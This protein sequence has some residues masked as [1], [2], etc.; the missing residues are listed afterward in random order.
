MKKLLLSTLLLTATLGAAA[1]NTPTSQMEK[2][3]RGLVVIPSGSQRFLSWR[4][5][6]TDDEDRTRF[7]I[8]RNGKTVAARNLYQTSYTDKTAG[9]SYQIITLVDGVPV[10]TSK[11]VKPWSS[12]S[13]TISMQRPAAG[14]TKPYT[15][16]NT[17]NKEK[18]TETYTNGQDYTYSPNDCSVGDVDGDGEYEIFVKWDPSNARDNSHGGVTGIVLIDCYKLDGTF[19][20]RIDLG[21]NIRAGAHYTQYQVYDY[22]G[23]GRAELMCKTAPGSKDGEGNYVNQAATDERIKAASNTKDWVSEGVGRVNGGQE[24]LTVFD[25]LTGRA[26]HTIAYNPNRNAKS[27]L[28]EAA[29]TFNWD[30]RSGKSDLGSYGNRGERYLAATAY[31]DGTDKPASAIFC[32]GYYSFA[33]VWAVSFDGTKLIPRWLHRSDN[34]NGSTYSVVTY[35]AN[36]NASTKTYTGN[37]PTSGSG[38]G[39]MFGNGNHN[40]SVA[41]VDGDGYDEVVWGSSACDHDGR[42]LY[43]TG[44]G[45]GDAIHIG[46]HCPDRPGLEVFQIHEAGSYGWDLHDA[47]TG[48]I[49]YSATGSEDNGRGIAGAFDTKVRGSLFWSANDRQ[50]RSAVTGQTVSSSSGSM[51]FRIYWD[52]DLYEELLDGNKI[53]KWNGNG[54]IRLTTLSGNTCNGTKNT[55]NLQAD[56]LGDWREEVILWNGTTNN[57]VLYTPTTKTNYRVPTLMH[58][59]TYRMAICWQNSAYNQ[60]PHLGYY[61][62]DTMLPTIIGDKELTVEAGENINWVLRGRYATYLTIDYK[63]VPS[64]MDYEEDYIDPVLT[65]TGCLT[66]AG[67]YVL[68]ITVTGLDGKDVALSVTI[69]VTNTTGITTAESHDGGNEQIYD[70]QGR[71]LSEKPTK[72]IVII[73]KD[74]KSRKVFL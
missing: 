18:V 20:W 49:L 19:L 54:T 29:G 11:A 22:D 39:T 51:N 58:D 26:I 12:T 10:D 69:H 68:P 53:D 48:K 55:P 70:L 72:G 56:I 16:T 62:P 14:K 63:K 71:K 37:K 4:F 74:G 59:H 40:I 66:Q 47:A 42:L 15:V 64:G 60:P 41:D 35:D 43:G 24:Y 46:D 44:Y 50:A 21:K 33:F 7:T 61:L 52:D 1:Q 27:E 57:L 9:S 73:V 23:D 65:L 13:L 36:G 3:D 38:S 5:L 6:G 67:D 2:L 32:R 25:G 17:I 30:S 28:S 34:A 8:L 45:H 31:I